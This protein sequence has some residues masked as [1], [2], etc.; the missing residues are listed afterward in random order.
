MSA[1]SILVSIGGGIIGLVFISFVGKRAGWFKIIGSTNALLKSNIAELE[2][3]NALLKEQLAQEKEQHEE[4]I[5]TIEDE[6]E[7]EKK[8]WTEKYTAS[9]ERSAKLEG[10]LDIIANIP[11]QDIDKSLKSLTEVSRDN[12]DSNKAILEQ[13]KASADVAEHA[14][15]DGGLL[16]KT[17]DGNPLKVEIKPTDS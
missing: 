14:Q 11:L 1:E 12:A 8:E 4:Q 7:A 6:H 2:R 3:Q 16:V 5:K 15:G 17:K 9:I 10:K 13:L